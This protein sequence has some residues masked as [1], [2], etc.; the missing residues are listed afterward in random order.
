MGV[1]LLPRAIAERAD[2]RGSIRAH[3]LCHPQRRV[4]TLF[5]RHAGRRYSS[6][7]KSL[8]TCLTAAK[9]EDISRPTRAAMRPNGHPTAMAAPARAARRQG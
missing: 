1:T 6:A 3:T 5:V 9:T 8:V 7:L 4:D 2:F